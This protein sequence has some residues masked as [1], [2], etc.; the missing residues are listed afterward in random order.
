MLDEIDGVG[1]SAPALE[2]DTFLFNTFLSNLSLVGYRAAR[3]LPLDNS[4]VD[5]HITFRHD[6]N[7][8]DSS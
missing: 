1:K 4:F 7:E 2:K 6:S 5:R 3:I 8:L